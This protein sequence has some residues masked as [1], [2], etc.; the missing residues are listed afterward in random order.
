MA[1]GKDV[2]AHF[3]LHHASMENMVSLSDSYATSGTG[4]LQ[5]WRTFLKSLKHIV[6]FCFMD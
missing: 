2:V 5:L 4:Y 3:S 1:T 6:I